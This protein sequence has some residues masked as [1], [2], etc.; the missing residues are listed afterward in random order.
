VQKL[1]G[2]L[3]LGLAFTI[4][5]GTVG[6]SKKTSTSASPPPTLTPTR[7]AEVTPPST[8]A[9][10]APPSTPAAKEKEKTK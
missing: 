1:L 8:P 5:M 2:L 4:G 10:K 6:C 3:I 7:S 9:A